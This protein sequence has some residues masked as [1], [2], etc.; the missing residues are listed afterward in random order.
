M[1][2][3]QDLARLRALLTQL[4]QIGAAQRG[5]LIRAEDWNALVASVA[6]IARAVLAADAAPVVPPH[7]HLDQ[8]G[9]AWLDARLRE[10]MQRGPLSDPAVQKRLTTIE[11]GLRRS[12]ARQD[13][14]DAKVAEF[15][16]R[17][18]DV[19]SRDLERQ[20]AV[21]QLRRSLESV[22]DPRPELDTFRASLRAVQ[23]DVTAVQQA[24]A[25]LSVGGDVVDLGSVL[26][27]VDELES[28]FT[29][30]R[31][32]N[33]ELLDA[34]TIEQRLA[35]LATTVVSRD[36]LAAALDERAAEVSPEVTAQIEERLSAQLQEQLS[37]QLTNFRG[38]IRADVDS[39]LGSVGEL[40]A[41]RVSDALPGLAQR[42]D[43]SLNSRVE[44]VQQAAAAQA[45]SQARGLI[46]AAT[47]SVR[48]ETQSQLA[49]LRGSL[50]SSVQSELAQQLS[51]E[52][53]ALRANLDA[54]GQRLDTLT[55]QV[56][57][58]AQVQEQHAA[59][60]ARVPQNIA[61]LRSELRQSIVS[62]VE[63]RTSALTRSLDERLSAFVQT[64][65]TRLQ[66][67]AQDV[68]NRALDAARSAA[69]DTARSET[70]ALRTQLLAEMRGIARDEI[71]V[72][73]RDQLKTAV[74]EAVTTRFAEVPG[75]VA[76]EVRRVNA[77]PA[78][79]VSP[80]A[81]AVP[82][83]PVAPVAPALGGSRR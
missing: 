71:S 18:T 37:G 1:P 83:A 62:E 30:L 68:Q 52:L 73:L 59:A 43:A 69:T 12:A 4:D 51:R 57:R 42:L 77:T 11:Q 60:I 25:K 76:T 38:G 46:D 39:R 35:E 5:A 17:L 16:G 20:A 14:N 48:S 78:R 66:S 34:A 47:A 19:A 40:V 8:V 26:G 10:L 55:T 64:Q 21:T 61:A 6:D 79:V 74:N 32:A 41:T 22:A 65:D 67:L 13:S 15:R 24:A 58:Q 53:G 80:G 70:R 9:E 3:P 28:L 2:T 36:E 23:R 44:A 27:R 33:G 54:A 31:S 49:D 81:P 7:E 63:L 50:L 45:L 82:A 75:L 56:N 72:G 29:R